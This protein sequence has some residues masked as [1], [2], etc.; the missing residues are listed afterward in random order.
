MKKNKPTDGLGPYEI[1][2][3]RSAVRQVWHRSMARRLAVKK[4]T[5]SS[6]FFECEKCGSVV[7]GIKIDHIVP[8]GSLDTG[9]IQ[10]LFCPSSELQGLCK[11]CHD[12]KSRHER[13]INK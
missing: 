3:I 1:A 4:C 2:K 11:T 13:K 5:N 10:R 6:G 8:V 9:F 7:P 12:N